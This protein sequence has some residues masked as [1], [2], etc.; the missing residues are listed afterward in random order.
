MGWAEEWTRSIKM[1]SR[2]RLNSGSFWDHRAS[3]IGSNQFLNEMTEDQ[4]RIVAP[5]SHHKVLEIGP[6]SGRLTVPLARSSSK[7]VSVDPS[8][9]MLMSLAEKAR[10]EGIGNLEMMNDYWENIDTKTIGRFDKAVSS[11]SLFMLDVEKQLRRVSTVADEVFLFVPADIRIPFS[12]QEVMFGRIMVE[13]TDHVILSNITEDMGLEP[14]SFVIEYPE[15]PCFDSL[16]AAVKNCFDLYGVPEDQEGPVAE[17][18]KSAILKKGERYAT[19]D[20]R[21]V[22]VIWWQNS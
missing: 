4:I 21:G 6:G 5:S 8:S 12:V 13:H 9:R 18:I 1:T 7:V 3:S 10:A 14:V 2:E 20:S 19:S 22:G 16:E 17:H 15:A 11:F